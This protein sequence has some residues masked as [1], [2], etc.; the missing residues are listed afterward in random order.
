MIILVNYK[1]ISD[2]ATTTKDK[3]TGHDHNGIDLVYVYVLWYPDYDFGWKVE[4][5]PTSYGLGKLEQT[6]DF[7]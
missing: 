4:T 2:T 7:E 6:L 3:T 5:W 1:D